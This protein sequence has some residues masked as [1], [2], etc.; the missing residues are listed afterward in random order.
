MIEAFGVGAEHS[1]VD[2]S[3]PGGRVPNQ[4]C[5]V[6]DLG[7]CGIPWFENKRV[8]IHGTPIGHE[9]QS[10]I[11][12]HREDDTC[13]RFMD[14]MHSGRGRQ[15]GKRT[16]DHPL[17]VTRPNDVRFLDRQASTRAW[18]LYARYLG[19]RA[20]SYLAWAEGPVSN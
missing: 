5:E 14:C 3:V 9:A 2:V 13:I 20:V 17:I 1:D 15:V 11:R 10:D 12:R 18:Q 7:R 8:E 16:D 6:S 4:S 19:R